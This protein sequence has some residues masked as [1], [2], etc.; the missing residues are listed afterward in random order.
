LALLIRSK[1]RYKA[2][3]TSSELPIMIIV[4]V[5]WMFGGVIKTVGANTLA[6]R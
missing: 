1:A 2:P 5:S 4:S 3:D 6:Q